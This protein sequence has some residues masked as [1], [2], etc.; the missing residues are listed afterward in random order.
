MME[1]H[2]ELVERVHKTEAKIAVQVYHAGR[3]S[4]SSVIGERPVAP[5]AIQDPI[6]G[7]TPRELSTSEVEGLVEKFTQ[8]ARR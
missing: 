6:I 7:E 3:Q 8:A 2:K 5:S 1:E 4:H